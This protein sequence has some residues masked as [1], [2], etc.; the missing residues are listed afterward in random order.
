[1]QLLSS[2]DAW[3]GQC[4]PPGDG[5]HYFEGARALAD[6]DTRMKHD[7]LEFH[8]NTRRVLTT[9]KEKW[10]LW[11]QN[12]CWFRESRSLI[13]EFVASSFWIKNTFCYFGLREFHSVASW[14]DRCGSICAVWQ[15]DQ[16]TSTTKSNWES[17]SLI[18]EFVASSFWIKNT[19]CYFGLREFHSV[20]SW[21]DRC[22]SIC[23]VWQVD[24]LTSTKSNWESI[25]LIEEFVASSFWIKNTFC[26]FGLREFHSVASWDDRCG[27]ICAVW[28]VDQLT[29]TTKSN[30]ESISLIEEF[31]ASSFWIKTP[32][33]TSDFVNFTVWQAG[34]IGADQFVPFDR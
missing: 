8:W 16:L 33:A 6:R 31:V 30:W 14:D 32:F 28:Q 1:M 25:S 17:R 12:V 3:C 5:L 26:Y 20:A 9:L 11:F 7:V 34:M 13:E 24:Q 2:N 18:E 4:L 23:A 27:S 19:F 22:G 21:D 10:R 29:S 15:V